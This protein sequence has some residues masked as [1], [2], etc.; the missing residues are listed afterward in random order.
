MCLGKIDDTYVLC[1]QSGTF[2]K[3]GGHDSLDMTCSSAQVGLVVNLH[4]LLDVL[5]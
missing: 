3:T 5:L 1:R 2:I 4:E